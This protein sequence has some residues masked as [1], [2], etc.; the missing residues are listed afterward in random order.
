MPADNIC[1]VGI[2]QLSQRCSA[3]LWS[4]W[5]ISTSALDS[6]LLTATGVSRYQ[7]AYTAP[8][9]PRPKKRPHF[10]S[11]YSINSTDICTGSKLVSALK[12]CHALYTGPRL[13]AAITDLSVRT[14]ITGARLA[15]GGETSSLHWNLNSQT[16]EDS[17]N[18]FYIVDVFQLAENG[19]EPSISHSSPFG[20]CL[21]LVAPKWATRGGLV[22]WAEAASP[23]C[24]ATLTGSSQ[25]PTKR[26][27]RGKGGRM[28]AASAL[29]YTV[30]TG[31]ILMGL[32]TPLQAS[33][34]CAAKGSGASSEMLCTREGVL[35]GFLDGVAVLVPVSIPERALSAT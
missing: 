33:C 34:T 31:N 6:G 15:V 1:E 8:S 13:P 16:S 19:T 3:V 2:R 29:Y 10:N 21:Q 14:D 12:W 20:G 22:G 7:A 25:G 28:E 26:D 32:L 18:A 11:S 23:F 9:A 27:S 17:K 24:H 5:F 30:M 35:E 4:A